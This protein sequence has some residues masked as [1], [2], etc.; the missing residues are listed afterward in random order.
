MPQH[1]LDTLKELGPSAVGSGGALLWVK[2][3]SGKLIRYMALFILGFFLGY[4]IGSYISSITTVP[5]SVSCL[6]VGLFGVTLV[7]KAFENIE[8][9]DVWALFVDVVK[10][11]WSK[12]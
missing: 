6:I 4:F 10:S 1:W 2:V 8:K 5:E 11:R 12:R 3:Q 7:E 9:S